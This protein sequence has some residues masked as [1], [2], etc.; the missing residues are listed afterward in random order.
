[1]ESKSITDR[2]VYIAQDISST[3]P[4]LLDGSY[5]VVETP[6]GFKNVQLFP[7][8]CVVIKALLDLEARRTMT[9]HYPGTGQVTSDAV[10]A[11]TNAIVLAEPFG[12]GKTFEILGLLL[13]QPIPKAYPEMIPAVTSMNSGFVP[14]V[15][16]KFVGAGSL[17]RPN[18]V[19]VG[20]PVLLQWQKVITEHTTLR[21]FTIGNHSELKKFI[22]LY[23]R[24]ATNGYNIILL[25]N[26]V[27]TGNLAALGLPPRDTMSLIAAVGHVTAGRCWSRV[28]YD[29]FDTINIPSDARTLPALS[30]LYVSATRRIESTHSPSDIGDKSAQEALESYSGVRLHD[31]AHDAL[32]FTIFSVQ[33]KKEFNEESTR[34]PTA[35]MYRYVYDNPDDRIIGLMGAMKEEDADMIVEMIN[36]DAI[37]TAAK[38]MNIATNS[39]ADIFKRMLD[40]KYNQFMADQNI[41]DAIAA[42]REEMEVLPEMTEDGRELRDSDVET[43]IRMLKK[44]DVPSPRTMFA[45]SVDLE[46]AIDVLERDTQV[47]FEANSAAVRRVIDNVRAGECQICALPLKGEGAAPNVEDALIRSDTE[48]QRQQVDIIIVRCCGIIVCGACGIKGNNVRKQWDYKSGKYTVRGACANCKAPVYP[49]VDLIFVET[50]INIEDLLYARGDE[51]APPAEEE[52]SIVQVDDECVDPREKITNPKLRAL[53]DIING[54]VPDSREKAEIDIPKLLKGTRSV[55]QP[56]DVKRKVLLFANYDETLTLVEEF[57]VKQD[58]PFLRLGGTYGQ[59]A[60][61]VAQFHDFGTILLINSQHYCAGLNLQIATDCVF[62]H[63]LKNINVTAQVCGRAQRI[64]RTCDLNIHFLCYRNEKDL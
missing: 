27:V 59:M 18:L 57:L 20:A 41:L 46:A 47:S 45:R 33:N 23:N 29:D 44:G 19:V 35:N 5:D 7:H 21:V 61:T 10:I 34:I 43:I 9:V 30:T 49:N 28:V 1:M 60:D 63:K 54:R 12:S 39:V 64:G 11:T 52:K 42:T 24:G 2:A 50:K 40:N 15:T 16:R 32:L 26:G 38:A 37:G 62:F 17:I 6:D 22:G 48:E 51:E 58:V 56:K 8:Q 36:G 14:A 31:V 25:K 4:V 55:P 53:L 13:I 3:K